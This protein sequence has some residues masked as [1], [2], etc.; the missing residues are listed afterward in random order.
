[1]LLAIL[2]VLVVAGA[3]T[4]II[5][6]T[7]DSGDATAGPSTPPAS[8]TTTSAAGS[9]PSPFPPS[10]SSVL[11]PTTASQATSAATTAPQ[12]TDPVTSEPVPPTSSAAETTATSR[13]QNDGDVVAVMAATEKF[14]DALHQSDLAAAKAASC[15]EFAALLTQSIVDGAKDMTA[16]GDPTIAGDQATVPVTYTDDGDKK[17]DV[18]PLTRQDDGEWLVCVESASSTTE[19]SGG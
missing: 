17:S 9:A 19:S 18:M 2:A 14:L 6:L 12:T 10:S 16:T 5:L 4:G 15:E 1:V 7:R 8:S 11:E 3:T 13:G